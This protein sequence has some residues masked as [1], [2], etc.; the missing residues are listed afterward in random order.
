MIIFIHIFFIIFSSFCYSQTNIPINHLDAHTYTSIPISLESHR[1]TIFLLDQNFPNVTHDIE[2]LNFKIDGSMNYP[3][4][5]SI[6]KR[7]FL[8]SSD[9]LTMSQLTFLQDHSEYF[10]DTSVALKSYLRKDVN[11]LTQFESKSR[12]RYIY[13]DSQ[14]TK[15]INYDQK[16][17]ASIY[18]DS[19]NSLIDAGYMYHYE[20]IPTY[21]NL[22]EY[23][24]NPSFRS[25]ES[26]NFKLHYGYFGQRLSFK[27]NGNIQIANYLRP[28]DLP[29]IDILE[30][31]T[32]TNWNRMSI[33][34]NITEKYTFNFN[35]DYKLIIS[36]VPDNLFSLNKHY[37]KISFGFNL[38]HKINEIRFGID[39][40]NNNNNH[41]VDYILSLNKFKFFISAQ[42]NIY[43]NINYSD[44]TYFIDKIISR[45]EFIG[46]SFKNAAINT[47]L[48]LGY[49][50]IK[51]YAYFYYRLDNNLV[52][53]E[54]RSIVTP[55]SQ[56][57][58]LMITSPVMVQTISVSII[59]PSMATSPSRIGSFV[60]AAP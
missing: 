15:G 58:V 27:N 20:K 55:F 16:I 21:I 1:K 19:E 53:G 6:P 43:M 52:Y 37:H 57:P 60:F 38:N 36:D 30:Y 9:T 32:Q 23:P 7:I 5:N 22:S 14:Q 56:T 2:Y 13:D 12:K 25:V 59:G 45:N 11:L 29:D 4:Y 50:D 47:S 40:F 41:Y 8:S 10:Y 3:L 46:F 44:A 24:N 18:K 51:D 33:N 17:I 31:L 39:R 49:H 54:P 42:N 35:S 34:Y 48:I 28:V 26:Y